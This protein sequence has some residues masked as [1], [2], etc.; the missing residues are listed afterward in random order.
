MVKSVGSLVSLPGLTPPWLPRRAGGSGGSPHPPLGG[1]RVSS[2]SGMAAAVPGRRGRVLPPWAEHRLLA[3]RARSR[4]GRIGRP[5]LPRRGPGEASA[6]GGWE[7]V[8]AGSTVWAAGLPGQEEPVSPL[9]RGKGEAGG[10]EQGTVR[11]KAA[12]RME[13]EVM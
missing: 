6:G 11:P 12:D 5:G 9:Q 3:G 8:C 1:Q 10:R 13:R 7:P 2:P 4:R